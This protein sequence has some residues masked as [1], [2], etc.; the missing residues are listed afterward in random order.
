MLDPPGIAH[1]RRRHDDG[2]TANGVD[3]LGIIDA[4]RNL[5][6]FVREQLISAQTHILEHIGMFFVD[7]GHLACE[8]GIEKDEMRVDLTLF[9]QKPDIVQQLLA[10]FDCEGGNDEIATAFK[11]FIDF[12]RQRLTA[13][14]KGI[15]VAIAATIGTLAEDIVET[16]RR[17][18]V[19]VKHLLVRADITGEQEPD[20]FAVTIFHFNLD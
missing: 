17:I 10:A 8:R 4:L 6:A 15:I 2:A 20:G 14:V 3:R 13:G 1:A 18:G 5:K 7:P 11:R 16:R 9:D 19:L 12:A